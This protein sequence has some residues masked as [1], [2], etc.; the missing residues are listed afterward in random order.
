L[1]GIVGQISTFGF[2]RIWIDS[3]LQEMSCRG[4][5][6]SGVI[7]ES[8]PEGSIVLGHNR[9]SIN[10]LS[11]DGSQP[12]V[13]FSER[14]V[15][16][17][18]GEIYNFVELSEL[19][20]AEGITLRSGSDTEV[21][22]ELWSLYQDRSIPLL[23]GMF[24]F[25]ILDKE[26]RIVRLVRDQ[27]GIKPLYFVVGPGQFSFASTPEVLWP[28]LNQP[29]LNRETIKSFLTEERYDRGS[30]TF[31]HGVVAV[32]AGTTVSI[33]LSSPNDFQIHRWFVPDAAVSEL[34][35][36]AS[37]K[38]L[39]ELLIRS[40]EIHMRSDASI[41]F[42][43]S[44]GIDSSG[45]ICLARHIYP[46]RELHAF[47]YR[48]EG[49]KFSEE[50][51]AIKVAESV[52][53]TL[54]FVS[55]SWEEIESELPTLVGLQ[56][57]PFDNPRFIAQYF[58]F[59][60]AASQGFKVV[61]EGQGADEV[62]GGYEGY[63]SVRLLDEFRNRGLGA[64][65]QY[66]RVLAAKE[67]NLL[68]RALLSIVLRCGT[69]M[70]GSSFRRLSLTLVSRVS[71]RALKRFLNQLPP[72]TVGELLTAPG[73]LNSRSS[74]LRSELTRDT[75][76][77][78]LPK[79]LRHG[80]RNAMANSVENRV[81]YLHQPLVEFALSLPSHFLVSEGGVSKFILRESLRG[82]VPDVVLDRKDKVGFQTPEDDY[83]NF[84]ARR[85]DQ[86]PSRWPM[87]VKI[88]ATLLLR[89]TS[90]FREKANAI[91]S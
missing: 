15:V 45:L 5:D 54:H 69:L 22:L 53:A 81:P 16:V 60:A 30:Q 36:E 28:K 25:A 43:L 19:V 6:S 71:P 52:G 56:S 50:Q 74:F 84:L 58:V 12:M 70:L 39:R 88:R 27:F 7:A 9:L 17:F 8:N 76:W 68:P 49:D 10:D 42:A 79:L 3:A 72:S 26:T 80:D 14:Y 78:L 64:G 66:M 86:I 1:C 91:P 4:P 55:P 40:V 20:L 63:P 29:T 90:F 24:S 38:H 13:S 65:M 18:N 87:N 2:D 32:E 41:A 46:H 77:D 89:W 23:E 59:K 47:C 62:F 67:S 31:V 73:W 75:Y 35:F 33:P 61:L 44:G 57:E 85:N 11:E 34:D 51:W 48:P 82:I 83:M 21:L 37:K